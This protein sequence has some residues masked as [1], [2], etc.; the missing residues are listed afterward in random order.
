ML[1]SNV[2]GKAGGTPTTTDQSQ[3]NLA[4][5][6]PLIVN[7]TEVLSHVSFALIRGEYK[8]L[9]RCEREY[10]DVMMRRATIINLVYMEVCSQE[11]LDDAIKQSSAW[12]GQYTVHTEVNGKKWDYYTDRK[13]PSKGDAINWVENIDL[14]HAPD[15]WLP[16]GIGS[17]NFSA[18]KV[19][20]ADAKR[21]TYSV[22]VYTND[23][24]GMEVERAAF[25]ENGEMVAYSRFKRNVGQYILLLDK[26]KIIEKLCVTF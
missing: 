18:H 9:E 14:L 8:S 22:E 11:R 16:E 12:R 23:M 26:M 21:D 17:V 7:N 3:L 25:N 5:K 10:T 1:S 15:N 13:D 2:R 20:R 24:D 6:I 4:L 19:D